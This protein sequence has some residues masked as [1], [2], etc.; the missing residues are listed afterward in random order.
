[1]QS[2]GEKPS[3][4]DK[5]LLLTHAKHISYQL[6]SLA[7]LV[8]GLKDSASKDS[9]AVSQ[10][11]QYNQDFV[12][13]AADLVD[14]AFL[15]GSQQSLTELSH[16]LEKLP[17]F[18]QVNQLGYH[19][20]QQLSECF[21][22]VSL[23]LSMKKPLNHLPSGCK[24]VIFTS[25]RHQFEIFQLVNHINSNGGA[26]INP[27]TK[28]LFRKQD[29]QLIKLAAQ[30][31]KLKIM[32]QDTT[33]AQGQILL[34]RMSFEEPVS[35]S[36]SSRYDAEALRQFN[37]ERIYQAVS[38]AFLDVAK[39]ND[40]INEEKEHFTSVDTVTADVVK[41]CL[42]K[43]KDA[44]SLS[45]EDIQGMV[46][47]SL[48]ALGYHDVARAYVLYRD[49]KTRVRQNRL[50]QLQ[51]QNLLHPV[52]Q[53]V[54]I[55][56]PNANKTSISKMQM[57]E[58]CQSMFQGYEH[59]SL[60]QMLDEWYRSLFSG[61]AYTDF[62]DAAIMSCRTLIEVHPDYSYVAA[63]ILKKKC[64]D[65][66]M[67]MLDGQ[68]VSFLSQTEDY[69]HTL[70]QFIQKGIDCEMINPELLTFDLPRLSKVI[71]T[72]RDEQFTYL[73][74]QTLYDRYFLHDNGVRYELPQLFFMRVAMG[75]SLEE[76]DKN[77]KAI[78]FYLQL[79]SFDSMCATATL[80]NSGLVHSQLS[81]CFLTTIPDDL[82]GIYA[83]LQDNAM[84]SK[85]AGGL[86]NDWTY[87]RGNKAKIK[88]TN[89]ESSGII[90]FLNVADATTIAVNQG[91]KRKGATCA[92][93]ET[94]HI[95]ILDFLE[96]RKNTGDD[97]RRTHDMNTANWIP[98][99]FMERVYKKESWTLFSPD[100]VADLHST[101]GKT[102]RKRYLAYESQAKE[103]K[104]QSKSIDAVV[105]WR[106]MLSMV[107][108]TGH[109]WFTF[110]DPCNLRSPQQHCGTVH[111]S[112]L[113]TE[114]TLNTSAD[115]I[116]V[117]NL[118]SINIPQHVTKDGIDREKLDKTVRTAVRML[119]NVININYY[120]V[121]QAK[122]SNMRHRPVGLGIMG[123]QDALYILNIAYES[124][125]AIAFADELME[126]ISYAAI[127]ASCNLAKEHGAYQS[128]EGSLWSQG[129]LPIDSIENLEKARGKEYLLQDRSCRLDWE[130]LR[131][132]VK[133]YGMRNSNVLAIAPT[134]TIAN[135][136]GVTQSIE[137]TY[138]NLFVKSNLSGEFTVVN[139][140][141]VQALLEAGLWDQK[142]VNALKISNGSVQ[143][144]AGIPESIKQRFKTAFEM[145]PL[146]L[147][148]AASMRAKWIDQSQSLN[149]YMAKASGKKLDKL[150]KD[151]WLYGLKTT[152]YLRSLGATDT[153]KSSVEERTLNAVTP[154]TVQACSIDNPDCEACQ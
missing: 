14:H 47:S 56:M 4:D 82:H 22:D 85:F 54:T 93:L 51:M 65:E 108:E 76:T 90:P 143:S 58:F 151:A 74:L 126:L 46:E 12:L 109:P 77:D 27:I 121:E 88:G 62:I 69:S 79:S 114:I 123:F 103:G 34:K 26:F 59:L 144:I 149:L 32:S 102:F 55:L 83:S 87:V 153:E 16:W 142:M 38:K 112:N 139:P 129:I 122:N 7:G 53:T 36:V 145:D 92:Y 130:S 30:Q 119:D 41:R 116:A 8:T 35:M 72:T 68:E 6:R 96:L 3:V 107:F 124:E 21:F 137:P 131:Q 1:M 48:M 94:W 100:Q 95:D 50:K 135:I 40:L 49:E 11:G 67:A 84:L 70:T 141:L 111:S 110:K 125:E 5:A 105:L 71:D 17:S 10:E 57:H 128:F 132:K 19:Y 33:E 52:V 118:A 140:H 91:G 23:L 117:C 133:Q 136:C 148:R 86:G 63:R 81:S 106:K 154:N 66:G 89:G 138:K 28:L 101:F 61:I 99:L 25:S 120:A 147:I 152:Y 75:L 18:L 42:N 37:P 150:Y 64:V 60:Q 20:E 80:F 134:A 24:G 104:I 115:E 29:V 146:Y 31:Q 39:Y 9:A 97:R 2:V 44:A 45:V 13:K 43:S 113:C 15:E 73:G 78:E 98:D 127:D